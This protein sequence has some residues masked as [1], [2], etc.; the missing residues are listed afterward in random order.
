MASEW[1]KARQTRY[2][3]FV[4]LYLIVILAIVIGANWLADRRNKTFDVTSNKQY[5]LSD[6]TK[7][8]TGNLTVK[9]FVNNVFNKL[10]YT[11]FYQSAAPFTLE[12]PGRTVAV[13]LSARY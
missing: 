10:Y 12:A 6:E 4:A 1:I 8:V 13:V 2:G 11:A 7:K 3:A 9:L 5:T